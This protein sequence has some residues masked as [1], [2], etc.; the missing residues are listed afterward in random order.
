MAEWTPGSLMVVI[1]CSECFL[2]DAEER[3]VRHVQVA[4]LKWQCPSGNA[5]VAMR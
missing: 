3:L 1:F 4:M 5:Q 2:V